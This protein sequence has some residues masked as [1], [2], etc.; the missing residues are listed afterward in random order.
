MDAD[1]NESQM[2]LVSCLTQEVK[3][4]DRQL[5]SVMNQSV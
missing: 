5:A 3:D 4:I 1:E 2:E